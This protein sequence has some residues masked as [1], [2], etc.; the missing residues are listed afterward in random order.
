MEFQTCRNCNRDL[1]I[2]SFGF[3]KAGVSY[4]ICANCRYSINN[5]KSNQVC[6]KCEKKLPITEFD[7][8]KDG[9]KYFICTLCRSETSFIFKQTIKKK[10]RQS[11]YKKLKNYFLRNYE[12]NDRQNSLLDPSIGK[13]L[14]IKITSLDLSERLMKSLIR[15]KIFYIRDLVQMDKLELLD[16]KNIGRKSLFEVEELLSNMSLQLGMKMSNQSEFKSSIAGKHNHNQSS[17]SFDKLVFLFIKLNESMLSTRLYNFMKDNNIRYLGELVTVPEHALRRSSKLG[18]KSISE[19]EHLFSKYNFNFTQKDYLASSVSFVA[20]E[21]IKNFRELEE[22]AKKIL[23][24][25]HMENEKLDD[26][27]TCEKIFDHLILKTKFQTKKTMLYFHYG[28]DSGSKKVLE[29]TGQ[30]FNLTRERIRQITS[31]FERKALHYLRESNVDLLQ[32]KIE[33]LCSSLNEMLPSTSENV[34][35][36]L[37]NKGYLNKNSFMSL[38]AI[39]EL[40]R[41]MHIND[42]KNS[43]SFECNKRI[44]INRNSNFNLNKLLSFITKYISSNGYITISQISNEFKLSNNFLKDIFSTV[45]SDDYILRKNFI[46]NKFMKKR[47]RLYNYLLKIFFINKKISK[48]HLY[49]AI[50]KARRIEYPPQKDILLEFC[51]LAFKSQED[52]QYITINEEIDNSLSKNENIFVS[53]FDDKKVFD[54]Y[55]LQQLAED[56]G[57]N[58]NSASVY[59]TTSPLIRSDSK[60]YYLIGTKFNDDEFDKIRNSNIIKRR[61]IEKPWGYFSNGIWCGF[62]LNEN[63]L[64]GRSFFIDKEVFKRIKNYQFYSNEGQNNRKKIEAINELIPQLRGFERIDFIDCKIGSQ[65]ICKFNLG[66]NSIKIEFHQDDEISR[67]EL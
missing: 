1:S 36:F 48:Q 25:I 38:D 47:N 56:K 13:N 66:E 42:F 54:F 39:F 53:C 16:L 21:S 45:L 64:R 50:K 14:D 29:E 7:T 28:I 59:C 41:I 4:L 20:L 17:F 51:R 3:N 49:E 9:E 22:S 31:K 32:N 19:I 26:L 34:I 5:K 8:S 15:E 55:S 18:K 65:L 6:D 2:K 33:K 58:A 12:A 11:I 60:L 62:Y 63:N 57:I 52:E 27:N 30:K 40:I 23:T 44:I 10:N 24:T 61:I 35:K 67:L 37:I 43:F 46:T